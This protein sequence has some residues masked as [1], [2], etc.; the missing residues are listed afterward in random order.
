MKWNSECR[1]YLLVSQF[2]RQYD[3]CSMGILRY[4]C[5]EFLSGLPGCGQPNLHSKDF[6][7]MVF[8]WRFPGRATLSYKSHKFPMANNPQSC[9]NLNWVGF[10]LIHEDYHWAPI[11]HQFSWSSTH[12]QTFWPLH[13]SFWKSAWLKNHKE[14]ISSTKAQQKNQQMKKM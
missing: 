5:D 2:C 14:I 13:D 1:M 11:F 6:E 3:I 10:W 7:A 8:H 9:K 12:R 4:Y